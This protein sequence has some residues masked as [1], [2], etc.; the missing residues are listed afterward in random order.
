MTSKTGR[1]RK[2]SKTNKTSKTRKT[3]RTRKT[4]TT[5]EARAAEHVAFGAMHLR[6]ARN[7]K[8]SP[9]ARKAHAE[10]AAMHAQA[11]L[12]NVRAGRRRTTRRR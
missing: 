4:G 1:T 7:A 8:L 2:T 11:A 9:C 10:A 12:L 6:Q 3:G 5:N